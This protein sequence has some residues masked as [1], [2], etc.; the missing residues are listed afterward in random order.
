MAEGRDGRLLLVD[1]GLDDLAY[2]E[3]DH[4]GLAGAGLGL[5]D[6]VAASDDGDDGPLLDGGGLLEAVAVD[7]AEQVLADPHGV[8]A[9]HTELCQETS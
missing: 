9:A 5:G 8:E 6:D 4:G 3:G 2:G 7:A 1:V